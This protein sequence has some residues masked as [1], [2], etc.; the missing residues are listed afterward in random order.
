MQTEV[1]DHP[2]IDTRAQVSRRRRRFPVRCCS[3]CRE[4]DHFVNFCNSPRLEDFHNRLIQKKNELLSLEDG[5]DLNHKMREFELWLC[6]IDDRA[7]LKAYSVKY[8]RAYARDS[9]DRSIYFIKRKIW[10][11]ERDQELE[12][13]QAA[14]QFVHLVTRLRDDETNGVTDNQQH[15]L[16]DV[17]TWLIDRNP[18]YTLL[19]RLRNP[20]AAAKKLEIVWLLQE[21]EKQ[22][23]QEECS[24]CYELTEYSNKVKLNCEHEFCGFCVKKIIEKNNKPCCAFCR[25]D[26]EK[27]TVN[28]M[29]MECLFHEYKK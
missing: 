20:V 26:L 1:D 21:E 7:L 15:L 8:C 27:I 22:H 10:R 3:F 24:I 9:L 4:D 19:E 11:E 29:N 6:S 23:D 18:D 17:I 16:G 2:W 5:G 25:V 12:M 28:S 13:I 14:N